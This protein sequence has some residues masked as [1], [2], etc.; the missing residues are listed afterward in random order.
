MI[1]RPGRCPRLFVYFGKVAN[2]VGVRNRAEG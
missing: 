1:E 2:F